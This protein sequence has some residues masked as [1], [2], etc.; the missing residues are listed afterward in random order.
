MEQEFRGKRCIVVFAPMSAIEAGYACIKKVNGRSLER[1]T[2]DRRSLYKL[3][4][5]RLTRAAAVNTAN[6]QYGN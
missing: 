5:R 4:T 1:D 6:E 2:S 3:R